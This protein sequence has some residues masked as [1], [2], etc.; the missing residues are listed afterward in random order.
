M[1]P[2]AG[3]FSPPA[4]KTSCLG[5]GFFAPR[6]NL[7]ASEEIVWREKKFST[8]V[9]KK[10]H[11][12]TFIGQFSTVFGIIGDLFDFASLRSGEVRSLK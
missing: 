1:R 5:R 8:F 9:P 3:L 11:T 4:I 7:N 2:L 12:V 6:G 10:V